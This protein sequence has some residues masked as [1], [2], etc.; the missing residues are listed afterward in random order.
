MAKK[1][2]SKPYDPFGLGIKLP[3]TKPLKLPPVKPLKLPKSK[4]L[5]FGFKPIKATTFKIP[6]PVPIKATTFKIPKPVPI[7]TTTFKLSDYYRM[8]RT[9][10]PNYTVART[11]KRPDARP[12]QRFI[13]Q[14]PKM[15][16][17]DKLMKLDQLAQQPSQESKLSQIHNELADSKKQ[18]SELTTLIKELKEGIVELKEEKVNVIENTI[19]SI[20]QTLSLLLEKSDISEEQLIEYLDHDVDHKSNL[21]KKPQFNK[22]LEQVQKLSKKQQELDKYKADLEHL[23]KMNA[24]EVRDTTLS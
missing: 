1:K 20:Q 12:A 9:G 17:F 16:L 23:H 8:K 3:K 6:K 14:T 5:N 4:P 7:K 21:E 22:L 24:D 15:G 10:S 19:E 11:I 2:K 13:P 18:V